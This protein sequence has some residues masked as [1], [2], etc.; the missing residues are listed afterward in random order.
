MLGQ[1][2]SLKNIEENQ[3]DEL[4]DFWNEIRML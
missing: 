2:S 1:S 4:K 3:V